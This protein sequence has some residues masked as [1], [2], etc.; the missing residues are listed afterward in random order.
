MCPSCG[1]TR[2]TLDD[3]ERTW[4]FDH[5][6]VTADANPHEDAALL[7]RQ[8]IYL[9]GFDTRPTTAE[10]LHAEQLRALRGAKRADQVPS[11]VA[12]RSSAVALAH[13]G[14]RDPLRAF[15]QQAP[16]TDQQEQANLNYWAYWV[17]EIDRVEVDDGFMGRIDPRGWAGVRLLGHLLERL[18]PDSAH[19][20]LNIHTV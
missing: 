10:W 11:W 19:V 1:P 13:S 12:V 14:D 20:E 2:P 9:L 8:A 17:G 4:F 15:V 7:R 5:F 6:L 16:A 3:R 18:H